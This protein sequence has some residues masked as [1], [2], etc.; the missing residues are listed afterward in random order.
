MGVFFFVLFTSACL[1]A[2]PE[3]WLFRVI[4]GA[5]LTLVSYCHVMAT[6]SCRSTKSKVSVAGKSQAGIA[7]TVEH[8]PVA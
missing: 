3:G 6:V 7:Q 1:R 5:K 2:H 8:S 4:G